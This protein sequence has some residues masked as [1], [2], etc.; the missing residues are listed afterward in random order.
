MTKPRASALLFATAVAVGG[1]AVVAPSASAAYSC[2]DNQVCLYKNSDFTGSVYILPQV[3]LSDGTKTFCA[4]DLSQ[5]RY[6]DGPSVDNTVSSIVN[7]SNSVIFLTEFK[8]GVG[9]RASIKGGYR[10]WN[11]DSVQTFDSAGNMTYESFNDR[12]SSAC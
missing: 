9:K 1:A 6:S 8:N 5:D 4:R 2:A 7:N 11:L 12:A 10:F 3:T